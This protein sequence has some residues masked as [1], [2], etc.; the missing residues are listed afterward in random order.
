MAAGTIQTGTAMTLRLDGS[1]QNI[2]N[3]IYDSTQGEQIFAKKSADATGTVS[4][5]VQGNDGT[6]D[7]YYS[8]V[9]TGG[10]IISMSDVKT[11]LNLSSDISVN[12]CKIWL[13]TTVDGVA[14]AKPLSAGTYT[15][16]SQLDLSID[17]PVAGSSLDTQAETSQTGL[18]TSSPAVT[19]KKG[20]EDATGNAD[21]YAAYTA[22]TTLEASDTAFFA[23]DPTIKVN[24]N[25]AT[26]VINADGTRTVSFVFPE[27]KDKL[28]SITQPQPITVANK[29]A[30]ADMNLPT[31]V[32]IVTEGNTVT[33]ADVTWNTTAPVDGAYDP[34]VLTEQTVTLAGTVTCPTGVD[35]TGVAL[36]TKIVITISAAGVTG[37]P[38]VNPAA[39]TYT[40]NQSVSLSTTTDGATIYYTTD[41]TEPGKTNGTAYTTPISVTGTKGQS[42]TVTIKA[43]AV[44]DGMQ[45]SPVQTFTYTINLPADAPAPT[46]EPPSPVDPTPQPNDD[47]TTTDYAGGE[48][49]KDEVPDTGDRTS[50]MIPFML[51]LAS[52]SCCMLLLMTNGRMGKKH[53]KNQ[54]EQ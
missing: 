54:S 25:A 38:A 46:P 8:K 47:D 35:A 42:V 1:N 6:N 14:Y 34:A 15:V 12:D 3:V 41:G 48:D 24:G 10:E 9:V 22:Y 11:A 36:E 30:Y 16:I 50:P 29:T 19:W 17:V 52:A 23:S 18:V 5:V 20:S 4:L 32:A 2:G 26:I 53:E 40:E 28:I 33:S 13:E 45:D 44:K 7:W 37:A 21:Y 31:T 39:G 49:G 43:I 51:M 27:T